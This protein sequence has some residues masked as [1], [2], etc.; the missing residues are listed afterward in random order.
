[1]DLKRKIAMV[2]AILSVA[3]GAGYILQNG[4]GGKPQRSASAERPVAITPLA[5]G[6]GTASIPTALP[7]AEP[8]GPE[9]P[10]AAFLPSVPEAAPETAALPNVPEAAPETAALPNVPEAE[11][12]TAALPALPEDP[13]GDASQ[14]TLSGD[15][16]NCPI[17]LDLTAAPKAMIEV[18]LLAPCRASERFV[19]RHSG[20]AVTGHTSLTGAFFTSL[21]ALEE[22]AIVSILF[23][24]Q[25][26][27]AAEL[28]LPDLPIYRRIGVQW[29]A[30]DNFQLHAFED[31]GV[32]GGEGHISATDPGS[33][34]AGVPSKT[35]FMTLLGDDSVD[36]PLLAEIY[37]FP[38]DSNIPV[39][40]SIEVS[41]TSKTCN[42]EL[43]GELLLSEGGARVVT[44]LSLATPD[45]SAIGDVLVLNNP[46][47]DL[48]L[49]AAN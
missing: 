37:T 16:T 39:D 28:N 6:L 9:L 30:Q 22:D 33:R 15:T 43:L 13:Y 46:L 49:A 45:C 47:P 25:M 7:Q 29:Q 5:A 34:L 23:G 12:E 2:S 1:M 36:L 4:M 21:P 42:R 31:G 40:I 38:I 20:L 14:V 26:E 18:T 10:E 19:L 41:V 44:D 27:V 32:Y 48:K 35:G 8:K 11:P 3:F 17:S 24:D